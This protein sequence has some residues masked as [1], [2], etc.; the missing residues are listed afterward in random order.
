VGSQSNDFKIVIRRRRGAREARRDSRQ[1]GRLLRDTGLKVEEVGAYGPWMEVDLA[2]DTKHDGID[3]TLI[4]V[5]EGNGLT[6]VGVDE[7]GGDIAHT[8][9]RPVIIDGMNL[10]GGAGIGLDEGRSVE[11]V[12]RG[13]DPRL[14]TGET[15]RL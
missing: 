6:G 14:R 13:K 1:L 4:V 12:L 10:H 8:G 5:E 9:R 11:E 3:G 15:S 7:E 2:I